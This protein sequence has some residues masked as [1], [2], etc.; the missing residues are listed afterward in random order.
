MAKLAKWNTCQRRG[1]RPHSPRKAENCLAWLFDWRYGWAAQRYRCGRRAVTE[2]ADANGRADEQCGPKARVAAPAAG[3]SQA[4]LR[5]W[6]G[7][8]P[9]QGRCGLLFAELQAAPLPGSEGG[10]LRGSQAAQA[11]AVAAFHPARASDTQNKPEAAHRPPLR[12]A[13]AKVVIDVAALIG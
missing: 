11:R 13:S 4:D 3:E 12:T 6:P 1:G 8:R 5:M 7:F 10:R 9:W 2:A